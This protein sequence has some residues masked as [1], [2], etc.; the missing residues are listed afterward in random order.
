MTRATTSAGRSTSPPAS[1][2]KPRPTTSSLVRISLA[3]SIPRLPASRARWIRSQGDRSAGAALPGDPELVVT[4]DLS[5]GAAQDDREPPVELRTFLLGEMVALT[6]PGDHMREAADADRELEDLGESLPPRLQVGVAQPREPRVA[7]RELREL[8]E[9]AEGHDQRGERMGDRR[10]SPVEEP[11]PL[12]LD[13][14]VGHMEVV[15]LDRLRHVMSGE[16]GA[17]LLEPGSET[18]E[19]V[20]LLA[21]ERQIA[22]EEVFEASRQR[23]DPEVRDAVREVVVCVDRLAS[24]ELGVPGEREEPGF[25]W[26]A[27]LSDRD[28]RVGEEE[29]GPLLVVGDHLGDPVGPS[30]EQSGRQ[31]RLEGLHRCARLEPDDAVGEGDAEDGRP[32][33]LVRRL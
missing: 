3:A 31:P 13:V 9:E 15:V 7:R 33:P 29:P 21:L 28:A 25:R 20:D 18:S 22:A 17:E 8:L 26:V 11:E 24:L 1:H 4:E 30:G 2:P 5:E 32:R 14:E 10:V 27:E 6:H 16:L 12:V 23:C 19:P